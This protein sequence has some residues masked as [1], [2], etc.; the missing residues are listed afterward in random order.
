MHILFDV[1]SNALLTGKYLWWVIAESIGGDLVLE[2]AESQIL[3][4]A[5]TSKLWVW[6]GDEMC[7]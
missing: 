6:F 2:V 4:D 7:V 3:G 5:G 1:D